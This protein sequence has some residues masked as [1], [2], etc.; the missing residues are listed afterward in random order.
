MYKQI[1]SKEEIQ[2]L[3]LISADFSSPRV[4]S[5]VSALP[6]PFKLKKKKTLSTIIMIIKGKKAKGMPVKLD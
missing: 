5:K 2:L 4:Y 3:K 6:M 1:M